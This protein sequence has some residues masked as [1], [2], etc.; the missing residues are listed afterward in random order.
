GRSI[1]SGVACY[2][3]SRKKVDGVIL[4]TP[5]DSMEMVAKDHYRWLPVSLLMRHRFPS[6]KYTPLIK[7]PALVIY[8]GED[9]IVLPPRT[10]ALLKSL[11]K[12]TRVLRFAEAGHN[13]IQ[14]YVPYWPTING[15][16]EHHSSVS[17]GK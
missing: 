10:E 7:A 12:S 6:T 11:P 14:L 16:I 2:V 8:G 4:V 3:A 5:F 1:G 17:T 9:R 13:D 15:F